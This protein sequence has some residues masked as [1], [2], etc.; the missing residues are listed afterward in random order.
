MYQ[1]E[2][3]LKMISELDEFF[4]H[5]DEEWKQ[6]NG[7]PNYQISNRA[8][9]KNINTNRMLKQ[10]VNNHGYYFV[11]L[12]LN[13]SNTLKKYIDLLEWHLSTTQIIRNALTT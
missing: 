13:K 5:H 2:R 7:Y 3:A 4:R 8:R 9:V 11:N 12:K 1:T 10:S 6:I